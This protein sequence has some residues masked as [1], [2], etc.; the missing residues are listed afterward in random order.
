MKE[1]ASKKY[2]IWAD[3]HRQDPEFI[4]SVKD[5]SMVT[6]NDRGKVLPRGIL[7][8]AVV[9]AVIE[10]IVDLIK[11]GTILH[12]LSGRLAVPVLTR[13][14]DGDRIE[15]SGCCDEIPEDEKSYQAL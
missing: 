12:V 3:E 7:M 2:K 11:D 14:V 8:D 5:M 9:E 13:L 1:H 15:E 4:Q 6:V 10:H